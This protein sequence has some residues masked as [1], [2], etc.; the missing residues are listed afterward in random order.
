M[1]ATLGIVAPF[2]FNGFSN[3]GVI[4]ALVRWREPKRS[5]HLLPPETFGAAMRTGLR[6]ARYHTHLRS[7]L[8]RAV[9]FF[10]FAS[11]YWALL[12][13]VA[14]SQIAGS[15]ALYGLLLAVIGAAAVTGAFLLPTLRSR[16]APDTLL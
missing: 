5:G 7:T 8:I 2:W 9:G 10:V 14:R 4:A 3:V 6:H 13:L 15:P 16:L 11:A 12:P 1:A